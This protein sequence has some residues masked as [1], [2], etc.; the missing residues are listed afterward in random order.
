MKRNRLYKMMY[1][2]RKEIRMAFRNRD[3]G[4]EDYLLLIHRVITRYPEMKLKLLESLSANIY[5]LKKLVIF[6]QLDK[7]QKI[8]LLNLKIIDKAI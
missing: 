7:K 6:L 1:I 8:L 4:R 5:Y 2:W 3:R